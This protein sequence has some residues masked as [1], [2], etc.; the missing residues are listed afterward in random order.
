MNDVKRREKRKAAAGLR[1][2]IGIL[3]AVLA[4][5]CWQHWGELGISAPDFG[6]PVSGG[7]FARGIFALGGV[8]REDSSESG[9]LYMFS[10]QSGALSMAA[11]SADA[12]APEIPNPEIPKPP[13]V[14]EAALQT[15]RP[16]ETAAPPSASATAPPTESAP[17]AAPSPIPG[18]PAVGD[19]GIDPYSQWIGGPYTL[20]PSD[21]P[22]AERLIEITLLP[23]AGSGYDNNG[24]V[25]V[26]N[27]VTD[28]VDIVKLMESPLKFT[29][30]SASEPQ[31]LI[32]H[33]HGSESFFP[34]ERSY[35]VPDD[36]KRT[37]DTR[38]NIVRVGERIADGLRA[39][40]VNVLHDRTICDYPSFSKAYE[41]SLDVIEKN[42]QEHPSIQMV[43]DV[44]RDSLLSE[45]GTAYKAVSKTERGKAAQLMYV[46]GTN[47]LGLKHPDWRS[48]LNTACA[49]QQAALEAYPTLMRPM[50]LREERFNQ[51]VTPNS[52]ILEVGTAWNTLQEALLAAD[53]FCETAGPVLA[54][55]LIIDN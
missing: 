15:P 55:Q 47:L 4:V 45:S 9:L 25:F 30:S 16:T 26:K 7:E 44:H 13:P 10:A 40:G 3:A 12:S 24:T 5:Q 29:K 11:Q 43:I 1:P 52:L 42:L 22:D 37:E 27:R 19:L 50:T 34:D 28:P 53:L 48:N 8:L 54:S 35:Y 20:P 51:H 23:S 31:V 46:V 2:I 18:L 49:L 41:K 39:H 36:I 14:H 38:F 17:P 33:T 21:S 32:V 6:N